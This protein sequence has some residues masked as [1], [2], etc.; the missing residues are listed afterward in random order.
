[1]MYI[2]L[3]KKLLAKRSLKNLL[4][5]FFVSDNKTPDVKISDN[6]N[7]YKIPYVKNSKKSSTC[8]CGKIIDTALSDV[9]HIKYHFNQFHPE[10]IPTTEETAEYFKDGLYN[11]T[12]TK[13]CKLCKKGFFSSDDQGHKFHLITVHSEVLKEIPH[14][15]LTVVEN[16]KTTY[17]FKK[18]YIHI[19]CAVRR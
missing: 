8:F 11:D 3:P 16:G 4:T 1:M 17:F 14:H 7:N 10:L 2:I 19:R 12:P 6:N 15:L 9:F 5:I 13:H 18:R